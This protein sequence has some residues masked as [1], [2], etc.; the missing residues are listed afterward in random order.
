MIPEGLGSQHFHRMMM[1]KLKILNNTTDIIE[2]TLQ[3]IKYA[4]SFALV[5]HEA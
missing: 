4:T 2:E 3:A 5:S 1:S